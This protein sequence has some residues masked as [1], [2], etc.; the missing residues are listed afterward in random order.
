M[1]C[2]K[3]TFT[4]THWAAQPISDYATGWMIRNWI[5][6]STEVRGLSLIQR[7]HTDPGEHSPSYITGTEVL[8]LGEKA[9]GR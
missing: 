2:Y 4:F 9:A 7:D 1:A 3:A 6:F 8:Y 5:T